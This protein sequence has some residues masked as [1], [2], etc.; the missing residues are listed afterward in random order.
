VNQRIYARLLEVSKAMKPRVQTGKSYHVS[1][2][3]YKSRII[4]IAT[5]DYTRMHNEKRFGRYENWKGFE[6]PYRPCIHSEIK[7]I[8][9][10]GEEDLSD[11]ELVNV[12]VDNNGN[13]N[14]AKACPNCARTLQGFAPRRV[15]YSDSEGNLQQDDRF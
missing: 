6:S 15:F 14:M 10:W 5:N 1:A 12:R 2:L 11:Y 8:T 7:L 13:P 9:K 4:C 3:V